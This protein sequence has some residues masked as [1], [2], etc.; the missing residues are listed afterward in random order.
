ML[1]FDA[2]TGEAIQSKGDDLSKVDEIDSNTC[3]GNLRTIIMD[4]K[5]LCP[6][7]Q[8]K[9]LANSRLRIHSLE[10]ALVSIINEE[11]STCN[12]KDKRRGNE[13]W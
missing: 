2:S 12:L 11:S 10:R 3:P 6:T 8:F 7:D 4:P 9:H 1:V 5:C 13:S